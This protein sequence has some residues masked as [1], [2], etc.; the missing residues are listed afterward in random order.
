MTWKPGESCSESRSREERGLEEQLPRPMASSPVCSFTK[1]VVMA[2][3]TCFLPDWG[4]RAPLSQ[5]LLSGGDV[6]AQ[7]RSQG[8]VD[9]NIRGRRHSAGFV[10]L[11]LRTTAMFTGSVTACQMHT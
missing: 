10:Y 4:D 6:R 7:V 8:A 9:Y 3:S 5:L 1:P 11:T 2:S